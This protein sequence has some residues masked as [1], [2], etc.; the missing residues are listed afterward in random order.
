VSVA[1]ALIACG[2]IWLLVEP[3][4]KISATLHL[5]PS[6]VSGLIVDAGAAT[7][8][9]Q[10]IATEISTIKSGTVLSAALNSLESISF[11]PEVVDREAHLARLLDVTTVTDTQLVEVSITGDAPERY[12]LLVNAVVKAHLGNGEELRAAHER[13]ILQALTSDADNLSSRLADNAAA[14][15]R[16]ATMPGA[17]PGLT[18]A[19]IDARSGALQQKFSSLR[20]EQAVAQDQFEA[21]SAVL[22][23]AEP[24][25]VAAEELEAF[26]NK[27]LQINLYNGELENIKAQILQ[28]EL[29]GQRSM[30]P[31]MR[32]LVKRVPILHDRV[33]RRQEALIGPYVENKLQVLHL[34]LDELAVLREV[35]KDDLGELARHRAVVAE[36]TRL[37]A[38]LLYAH[39]Q[40]E[41]ELG[42]VKQEIRNLRA[43]SRGGAL[44]TV[45]E[46]AQVPPAPNADER[47]LYML[48]AAIA[49][50]L[51]GAGVAC[52]LRGEAP[53]S[54]DGLAEQSGISVLVTVVPQADASR[55]V[56]KPEARTL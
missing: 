4:Y 8:Y 24:L 38:E 18:T 32:N 31:E 20:Q 33:R 25:D 5:S 7:Q 3:R 47:P 12:T 22:S 52:S 54:H 46:M 40:M 51:I 19:T 53:A 45:R 1:L 15:E 2:S 35:V 6:A 26:L 13:K 10:L 16:A 11:S 42:Q 29:A 41:A 27:D 48:V 44:L 39:E 36:R 50:I 30:H 28:L 9:P 34:S 17:P 56:E 23:G 55:L 49:S 14:R 37:L 21:L 43:D